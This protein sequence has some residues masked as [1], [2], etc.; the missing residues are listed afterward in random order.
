VL[1]QIAQALPPDERMDLP[2]FISRM[3]SNGYLRA[4]KLLKRP[5]DGKWRVAYACGPNEPK[6]NIVRV[7]RKIRPIPVH[8]GPPRVSAEA[9]QAL[10]AAFRISHPP[11]PI[12]V[13][14]VLG[15]G[16]CVEEDFAAM[17]VSGPDVSS[18]NQGGT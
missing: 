2:R 14:T 6:L 13:R 5:A 10:Y 11:A 4:I 16:A 8:K 7:P 3:V 1:P 18:G 15:V 9:A 12:N 17:D